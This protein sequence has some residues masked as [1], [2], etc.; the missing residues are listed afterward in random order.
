MAS[1]AVIPRTINQVENSTR[2]RRSLA[3]L[4]A[5]IWLAA[6]ASAAPADTTTNTGGGQHHANMQPFTGV[7]HIIALNGVFPDEDRGSDQ[8]VLGEISMFG[9]NYAPGGWAFADG[10]LLP[11][12][13]YQAL[14]SIMG[15]MYGGDGETTFGLPDLRGRIAVG[16]GDGPGLTNRPIGQKS[17]AENVTLATSQIPVHS[18][19]LPPS[20]AST[21]NTGGGQSHTNMQ[22][23]Q[24]LTHTITTQGLFPSSGG[25]SNDTYSFLGEVRRFAGNFAPGET[26][27]T[28]G[29][30][31]PINQ[32]QAL[33]SILGTTYGGDGETSFGLPDLRGRTPIGKGTGPGLSPRNLGQRLG[34]ENAA[35]T[36]NNMPSHNHDWTH[37][38]GERTTANT[39][40]ST[41]H[42]N[43]QPSLGL[44]YIIALY[45]TYPSEGSGLYE[46]FIGEISLFAGNYEPG[47][48][49]YADGR[50]LPISSYTALFSILGTT[51]GGD[52]ET[53]F[54]LPDL[55]G[56]SALGPRTGPGLPTYQLGQRGGAENASLST[57]QLPSH[58]HVTPEPA[59]MALL[60]VGGLA[61]LRRKRRGA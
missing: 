31:L 27:L 8:V 46:G 5:M 49:A 42:E 40:G 56:R 4:L 14:F 23:Y 33:F 25:G 24:A 2:T 16:R 6:M 35:L 55:R 59:T 48:W 58:N 12:N 22:P 30:L 37:F 7:N 34:A 10:Q 15:T 44:N 18:H 21:F 28:D 52:G 50:L 54:G 13:Q 1:V 39:G 38:T 60:A 47:G 45:G 57:A 20:P 11:I 26:A 19:L 29:Q 3:L 17:G 41:P 53:T 43:M 36:T 9:G 32:N 61:M 51:Y